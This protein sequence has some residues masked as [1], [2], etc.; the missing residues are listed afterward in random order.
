MVRGIEG[1]AI[2]SDDRDRREFLHRVSRVFLECGTSCYAWAL[3][4]NHVHFVVRTGQR[5]LAHVMARLLTGYAGYF[6]ERH[7]RAGHLFQNRYKLVPVLDDDY[8]LVVIRYVHRNPLEAGFVRDAEALRRYPWGGHAALVGERTAA[9]QDVGFVL[10]RFGPSR[11]RARE[12]L[13]AWM[14]DAPRAPRPSIS[15]IEPRPLGVRVELLELVDRVALHFGVSRAELEGGLRRIAATDARA[16]I[17]HLACD[18]RGIPQAEVG[19]A[20]GVT[21]SAIGRARGRGATIVARDTR[22][23]ALRTG[24]PPVAIQVEGPR[25]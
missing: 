20:A 15:W 10:D 6:N 16:V 5:R 13:Q 2:F 22:L 3:M 23:A 21:G 4:P 19:C 8:L 17:A 1:R 12:R 24:V 18:D 7:A 25:S 9:F 14:E 11:T